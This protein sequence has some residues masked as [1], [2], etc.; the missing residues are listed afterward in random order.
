M[1]LKR[2]NSNTSAFE[3]AEYQG[4]MPVFRY[5]SG[6]SR[7]LDA[8]LTD[9]LV[10]Y[11]TFEDTHIDG[12][13]LQDASGDGNDGTLNGGITTGVDGVV[14]NSATFDGT[15]D[16]VACPVPTRENMSIVV[17]FTTSTT[18]P[19][20]DG[21]DWFK[22]AEMYGAEVTDTVDDFGTS[23]TGDVF[24]FGIGNPDTTIH[25]TST[26]TDGSPHIAI[27]TYDASSG[28]MNLYIDG[29]LEA[30]TSGP[31]GT[32]DDPN[33]TRI[34]ANT[35]GNNYYSGNISSVRVYD[36]LISAKE[37]D[38]LRSQGTQF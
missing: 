12:S 33:E 30:S 36:R 11:W 27:A 15:D 23:I 4:Q 19:A 21:S 20:S 38:A 18:Q 26:V 29:S 3:Q 17:W 31:T 25:S 1:T 2:Y 14:G 37:R 28:D 24:A 10:G 9:G 8:Y 5:D 6:E 16:Y 22:G 13:T 35:V 32:R 34:G 7:W